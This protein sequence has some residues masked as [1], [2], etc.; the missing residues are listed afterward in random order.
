[1]AITVRFL[2]ETQSFSKGI[3]SYIWLLGKFV[4]HHPVGFRND[5]DWLLR[6]LASSP[7]VLFYY[8]K[9]RARDPDNFVR[10][11]NGW[12]AKKS[13]TND[14]KFR[15]LCVAAAVAGLHFPTDWDW[16]PDRSTE[17]LV[18]DREAE[19]R[20]GTQLADY[21]YTDVREY[22]FD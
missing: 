5:R 8:D 14:Y 11:S 1:M 16:S 21:P 4:Q 10:L 20:R 9:A 18:K 3:E 12:C 17:G 22:G 2:G 7:E 15:V 13:I 6:Y 19:A